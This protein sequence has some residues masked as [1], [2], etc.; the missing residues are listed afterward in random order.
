MDNNSFQQIKGFIYSDIQREIDLAAEG[1]GAG[2]LLCALGLMCYTE[3]AGDL[4]KPNAKSH[5][6]RFNAFFQTLGPSYKKMIEN[7][8]DIY[9][10]L[11]CGLVHK[12]VQHSCTVYMPGINSE[13]GLFLNNQNRYIFYI[14][15]YFQD[16]KIAFENLERNLFSIDAQ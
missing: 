6:E 9:K 1:Q 8:I 11:R 15:K 7:N 5:T 12:Y 4:M 14:G 13:K 3:F 16:F 10:E 2:N